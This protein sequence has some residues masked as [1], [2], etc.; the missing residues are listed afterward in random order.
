MLYIILLN[1]LHFLAVF[2]GKLKQANLATNRD[3]DAVNTIC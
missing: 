1:L 2:D 3:V